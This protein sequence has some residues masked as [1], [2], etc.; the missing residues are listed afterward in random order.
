V[1][2][3]WK[4]PHEQQ[5]GSIVITW[6]A[7]IA[8]DRE[9]SIQFIQPETRAILYEEPIGVIRNGSAA[10]TFQ[11]LGFDPEREKWAFVIV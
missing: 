4:S 1:T 5:S 6:D 3:R 10:F 7:E 8:S 2:C 9:L 11:E